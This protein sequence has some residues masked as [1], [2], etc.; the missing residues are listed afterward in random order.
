MKLINRKKNVVSFVQINAFAQV[1]IKKWI[2]FAITVVKFS[3]LQSQK[4]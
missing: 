2:I 1:K 4:L 3:R